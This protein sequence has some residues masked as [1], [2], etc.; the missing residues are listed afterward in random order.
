MLVL[1]VGYTIISLWILAQPVVE[2]GAHEAGTAQ[3]DARVAVTALPTVPPAA[4]PSETP[5]SVPPSP[6]T[7]PPDPAGAL[8]PTQARALVQTLPGLPG[9]AHEAQDFTVRT[10]VL[11]C[12]SCR[13]VRLHRTDT[14]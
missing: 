6:G 14:A 4:L 7:P 13:V 9:E 5:L 10:P 12:R 1:M 2:E 3:A 11:C 8:A